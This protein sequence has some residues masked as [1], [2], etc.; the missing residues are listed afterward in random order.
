MTHVQSCFHGLS[1]SHGSQRPVCQLTRRSYARCLSDTDTAFMQ[2]RRSLSLRPYLFFISFQPYAH[3]TF[4]LE[5]TRMPSDLPPPFIEDAACARVEEGSSDV[6]AQSSP[7]PTPHS[8]RFPLEIFE[9][10]IDRMD[11]RTLLVAA[12]VCAAWYTRAMRNLYLTVEIRD[13]KSFDM[14]FKQCRASPRLKRW[15]AAT[16]KVVAGEGFV[17]FLHAL[18]L[19]LGRAISCVQV[20]EIW[21]LHLFMQS[22]FFLALSQLKAVQSLNL[23]GCRLNNLAQLRWIVC[24]FPQLTELALFDVFFTRQGSAGHAEVTPSSPP[25]AV[26]LRNLSIDVRKIVMKTIIDWIACSGMCTSL[27]DLA[28]VSRPGEGV[29]LEAMNKLLGAAGPSLT[30]FS[31]GSINNGNGDLGRN[32]AL[33]FLRFSL[34]DINLSDKSLADNWPIAVGQL[35]NVLSTVRSRQLK[36]VGIKLDIWPP[37]SAHEEISDVLE[38]L[39]LRTLHEIMSQPYFDALK[40]VKVE[41]SLYGLPYESEVD[42][43]DI[44]RKIGVVF[45]GM[46]RPWS[47]RNIV[48][49]S[50]ERW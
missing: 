13:R 9:F 50:W 37:V 11:N 20:L 36:R 14:L 27:E 35:C 30:C 2:P 18:P 15:L 32:I 31:E 39:D 48:D 7:P 29:S 1:Q 12:L 40:D 34:T 33:R 43:D 24:A 6:L 3:L 26:R 23:S 17:P 42:V 41:M 8:A 49:V 22:D 46:L 10:V 4:V 19:A 16:R 28:I 47:D 25:S 44:G 38:K 21:G 45:C 5:N